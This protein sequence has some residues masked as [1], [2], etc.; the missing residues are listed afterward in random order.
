MTL[1]KWFLISPQK[2]GQNPS[3]RILHHNQQSLILLLIQVLVAVF[4]W[5]VNGWFGIGFFVYYLLM[6][7]LLFQVKSRDSS[8]PHISG[9]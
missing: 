4:P 8:L 9:L 3:K 7:P 6:T 5:R 1:L 2:N